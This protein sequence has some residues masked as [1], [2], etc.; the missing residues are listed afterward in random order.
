MDSSHVSVMS[1]NWNKRFESLGSDHNQGIG[2]QCSNILWASAFG[3]RIKSKAV[4]T[5]LRYLLPL[6]L[7]QVLSSSMRVI[8]RFHKYFNV[9]GSSLCCNNQIWHASTSQALN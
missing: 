7:M 3:G 6:A 2:L 1:F 9:C 8:M 4:F 5:K